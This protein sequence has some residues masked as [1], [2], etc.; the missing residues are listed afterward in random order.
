[1]KP[2]NNYKGITPG[3]CVDL[4]DPIEVCSSLDKRTA[5]HSSNLDASAEPLLILPSQ[6]K[7]KLLSAHNMYEN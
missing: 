3:K 2:S 6:V 7:W 1:M 4:T 5:E